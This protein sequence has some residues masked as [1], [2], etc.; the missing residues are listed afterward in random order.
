MNNIINKYDMTINEIENHKNN[1]GEDKTT[2]IYLN[3]MD[4]IKNKLKSD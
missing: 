4:E 1:K 3:H 2:K